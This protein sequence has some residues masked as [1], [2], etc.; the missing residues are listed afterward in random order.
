MLFIVF[1]M[2]RVPFIGFFLLCGWSRQTAKLGTGVLG[3]SIFFRQVP[4]FFFFVLRPPLNP[5]PHTAPSAS[6]WRL[7]D[8]TL[9]RNHPN[10]N[11]W[12]KP[13]FVP[14]MPC[15][16]Q[17]NPAH[18]PLPPHGPHPSALWGLIFH[19][20]VSAAGQSSRSPFQLRIYT[21]GLQFRRIPS[22]ICPISWHFARYAGISSI[23]VL[24][25]LVV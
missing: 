3:L 1:A 7:P 17:A 18:R 5:K 13:Y 12:L 9:P 8:H 20:Q 10:I 21:G 14:G 24:N 4:W 11:K 23:N 22:L 15:Y 16:L 2:L 25:L 19:L 6:T